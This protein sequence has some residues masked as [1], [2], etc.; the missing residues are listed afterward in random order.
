LVVPAVLAQTAV[1]PS[2]QAASV[3]P[4]PHS[5]LSL[6]S[7]RIAGNRYSATGVPLRRLMLEAYNLRDFQMAGGPSWI[8]TDQWD[9]EAVA[10]DGVPLLMLDVEDPEQPTAASLMMQSL[11][12][13]RFQLEF[14]FETKELPVYEL[15]V[16]KNDPKFKLSKEQTIGTCLGGRGDMEVTANPFASF[17]YLLSRQSDRPLISK[18]DL[19]GLY[20][21]KLQWNPELKTEA[22]SSTF[23]DKPS[24]FTTLQEQLGLK[25]ES[26]KGAVEV[27]VIDSV[28]KPSEN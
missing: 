19:T 21:I 27:L 8:S 12:E 10:E 16:A 26:S 20:D 17:A 9:V 14:H 13:N 3:K 25:L 23:S 11:I 22:E 6:A 7:I 28:Q 24:I 1:K 5:G 2:F 15:T 4:N 18:V